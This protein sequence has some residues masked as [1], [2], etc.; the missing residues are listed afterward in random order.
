MSRQKEK[1]RNTY[2]FVIFVKDIRHRGHITAGNVIGMELCVRISLG[3]PEYLCFHLIHYLQKNL[4]CSSRFHWLIWF[5]CLAGVSWKWI[6]IAH[7]LII[8]W[9]ITIMPISPTFYF[10]PLVDVFMLLRRSYLQCTEHLIWYLRNLFYFMKCSNHLYAKFDCFSTELIVHCQNRNMD[11]F[12]NYYLYYGDGTEPIVFL[13]VNKF[14]C[15]MF[16]VGLA[17]GVTI[18]VGALLY[19]QVIFSMICNVEFGYFEIC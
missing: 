15:C 8:V 19:I 2:S 9:G 13:S 10:L 6:I 1:I 5:I 4:F 3:K 7:G 17:V 16:A 18:A 11:M 12:Q 14:I